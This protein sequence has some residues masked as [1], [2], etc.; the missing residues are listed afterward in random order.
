VDPDAADDRQLSGTQEVTMNRVVTLLVLVLTRV[1]C[2]A[3]L[4]VQLLVAAGCSGAGP[5]APSPRSNGESF[6]VTGVVTDDQGSPV[7][8]A[9]VTMRHWLGGVISAPSVQTD[10]SGRYTIGFT[11]NPWL[12]GTSGRGAAQAE[13]FDLSY[14]RYQRTVLA[15]SSNLIENF[16]LHGIQRIAPG[17]SLV[18]NIAPDDAECS[19]DAIFGLC[20]IVRVAA[21][22][23]GNMTVEARSTQ[24]AAEQ[25]QVAV[26]CVFGNER[27]GNPV[28][29]PVTSGTEYQLQIGLSRGITTSQSVLLKTSL[30]PL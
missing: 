24:P 15:T 22:A 3:A 20:R 17:D 9:V 27:D 30:S 12:I 4:L 26:C 28:T 7:G 6:V 23:D 10:A 18:L 11:A 8:D 13:I 1:A 19:T 16:R 29:L 14:E 21:P 5:A 2:S 25:P